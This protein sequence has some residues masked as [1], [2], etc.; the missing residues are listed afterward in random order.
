MDELMALW[1][2]KHVPG[3]GNARI[4]K[5]IDY[6]GSA[7]AAWQAD[8]ATVSTLNGITAKTLES[9]QQ[10]HQQPSWENDAHLVEK[11]KVRLIPY[12][13]PSYPRRLLNIND[14]PILLYVQGDPQA[15]MLPNVAV[16]GTRHPTPYGMAMA[17]SF[18][19]ELAAAGCCIVSGMARGI[20]TIAHKATVLAGGKTVAVLGSGLA[21]IYPPDNSMLA[22][23]IIVGGGAVVSELPM[24][25]PPDRQHFPQR[26]R[27]VS[28]LA[29]TVLLIEAPLKSG[30]LITMEH[31][32]IQSKACYAL[33]GRLDYPSF[34]G[35][36][37]LLQKGK[38]Q[39]A[40]APKDLLTGLG[41]LF[42]MP[43]APVRAVQNMPLLSNAECQL[44]AF[45]PPGESSSDDLCRLLQLPVGQINALLMSLCLKKLI[46]EYPGKRYKKVSL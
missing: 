10:R 9:W 42:N 35:N 22:H 30:A 24:A 11:Y 17:E 19:G 36:H 12:W 16:V 13:E 4:R 33:P 43:S 26:N 29:S 27:I 6:C 32:R 15:L 21:D 39:L 20:D 44:L 40:L 1:L 38:A 3:L 34:A 37:H 5:L 8:S 28:G 7:A 2:L 18:S 46:K 41:E 23:E 45:F 14:P 25:T 31:A